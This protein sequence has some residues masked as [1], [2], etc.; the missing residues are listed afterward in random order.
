MDASTIFQ[1][2]VSDH[3]FIIF[4]LFSDFSLTLYFHQLYNL[5][6]TKCLYV[7]DWSLLSD[8][9]MFKDFRPLFAKNE[10]MANLMLN[11]NL[12]LIIEV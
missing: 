12:Q 3:L 7:S 10:E 8:I 1:W 4:T 9:W 5:E 6:K 11:Y 2:Q